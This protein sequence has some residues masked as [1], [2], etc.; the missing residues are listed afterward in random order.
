MD[1]KKDKQINVMLMHQAERKRRPAA[2]SAAGLLFVFG[3]IINELG[4]YHRISL[5][6]E[7]L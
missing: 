7:Y 5:E 2:Y 1:R 4:I 6:A 3:P